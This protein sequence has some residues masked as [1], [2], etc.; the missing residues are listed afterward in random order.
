METISLSKGTSYT[1][2]GLTEGQYQVA[3]EQ[4]L[5]QWRAKDIQVLDIRN[6]IK[7]EEIRTEEINLE[8]AK[9]GTQI[10]EVNRQIRG[11]DL[12]VVQ[13]NLEAHKIDV[14]IA[15]ERLT[16][17]QDELT[18]ERFQTDIK[19]ENYLVQGK[20]AIAQLEMASQKLEELMDLGQISH[21]QFNPDLSRLQIG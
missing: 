3:R 6:L 19:R 9:I 13:I 17:K 21:A 11:V 7:D 14:P 10:A 5:Q 18:F 20:T 4:R 16:Q 1:G 15:Q 2:N 12:E 8:A